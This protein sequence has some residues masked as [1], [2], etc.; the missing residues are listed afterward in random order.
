MLHT[1]NTFFSS[2]LIA[3]ANNVLYIL[4]EFVTILL[5]IS[6]QYILC[7]QHL[8][9]IDLVRNPGHKRIWLPRNGG[10]NSPGEREPGSKT[11]TT[12]SS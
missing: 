9:E 10:A 6:Y 2:L 3:Q 12:G 4:G 11:L 5:P 8:S 1:V 7:H